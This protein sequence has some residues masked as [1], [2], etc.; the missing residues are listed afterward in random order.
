[1]HRRQAALFYSAL[2][3]S[4]FT[5]TVWQNAGEKL[6]QKQKA[7]TVLHCMLYSPPAAWWLVADDGH[8]ERSCRK[9]NILL[10]YISPWLFACLP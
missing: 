1:M 9:S 8:L 7:S 2:C 4:P 3:N 5:R 10:T 6:Q